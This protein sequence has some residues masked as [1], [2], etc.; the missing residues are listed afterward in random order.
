MESTSA[1]SDLFPENLFSCSYPT[2][3]HTPLL[4]TPHKKKMDLIAWATGHQ[5]DIAKAIQQHGAI[6]FQGFD[7]NSGNFPD[8]F[9]A[10]TGS[11]PAPYKGD[12]PREKVQGN[13]YHSTSVADDHVIPLHQEVAAKR[14]SMPEHIAFFCDVPPQPGT[15]QTTLGDVKAVTKAI[16]ASAPDI[17]KLLVTKKLTYTT[18]LLPQG[19]W[20]T[21]WIQRLN[22]SHATVGGYFG[23]EDR[24]KIQKICQDDGSTCT[25]DDGWAIVRREGVPATIEFDGAPQFGNQIHLDKFSPTLCGGRLKYGLARLFLYQ[26]SQSNQYDV[27]WADGTPIGTDV[28]ERLLSIIQKHEI[29]RTWKKGDLTVLDNRAMMHGKRPHQGDRRILVAMA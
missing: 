27:E 21:A 3:E 9:K 4:V 5:K 24:S 11:A 2:V 22:P 7:L 17:W 18:R 28:G 19:T 20:R 1:Q 6:V 26:T 23:T 14:E 25:W 8:A 10:I 16:Q 15:G 29:V 12:S 13:I